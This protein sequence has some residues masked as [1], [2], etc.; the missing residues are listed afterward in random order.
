MSVAALVCGDVPPNLEIRRARWRIKKSG[1]TKR[2]P[3][4]LD[5]AAAGTSRGIPKVRD[6]AAKAVRITKEVEAARI[7]RIRSRSR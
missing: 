5:N 4:G 2:V 7:R 6:K 1:T 3:T